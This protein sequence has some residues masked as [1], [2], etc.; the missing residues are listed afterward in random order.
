VTNLIGVD[1]QSASWSLDNSQAYYF[2]T[3]NAVSGYVSAN[4]TF[5]VLVGTTARRVDLTRYDHQAFMPLP[6]F[7]GYNC[8]TF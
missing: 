8:K 6:S 1:N 7:D 2:A 4:G 5:A 3:E